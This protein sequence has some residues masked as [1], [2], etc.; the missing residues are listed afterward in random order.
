MATTFDNEPE[1]QAVAAELNAAAG[2]EPHVRYHVERYR[3]KWAIARQSVR[4]YW[5]WDE[6]ITR[7]FELPNLLRQSERI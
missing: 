1:A 4:A 7:E 6:F 3:E 2:R 5:G